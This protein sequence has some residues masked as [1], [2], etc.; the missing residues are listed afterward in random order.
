MRQTSIFGIPRKDI[1]GIYIHTVPQEK[2][3][4][5]TMKQVFDAVNKSMKK[6]G[7]VDI[8]IDTKESMFNISFA[9]FDEIEI[10]EERIRDEKYSSKYIDIHNKEE[11]IRGDFSPS[12]HTKAFFG[13]FGF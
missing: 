12:K 7:F 1:V 2:N 10:E 11:E 8:C 13:F 5:G 4:T 3:K 6:Y 9:D